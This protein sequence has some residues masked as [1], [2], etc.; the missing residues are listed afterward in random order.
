MGWKSTIVNGR[1]AF[2]DMVRSLEYEILKLREENMKLRA[3]L[4]K[5]KEAKDGEP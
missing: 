3:E 1:R 4:V 2:E 5:L